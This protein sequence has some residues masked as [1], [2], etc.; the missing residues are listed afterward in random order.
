MNRTTTENA[1]LI[2]TLLGVMVA[3]LAQGAILRFR[4]CG[5]YTNV[6]ALTGTIGWYD[7]SVP[8]ATSLPGPADLIRVNNGCTVT[9]TTVEIVGGFQVGVDESGHLV[10]ASGGELSAVGSLANAVGYNG[11]AQN[12]YGRMTVNTNGEVNCSYYLHVGYTGFGVVTIDGGTL[13]LSH[14]LWVGGGANGN[15]TIILTNG[16]T[17]NMTGANNNNGMIGLGTINAVSPSGGIGTIKVSDGSVLNLFT[18]DGQG[19]SIQPG[20]VLDISGSGVVTVPGDK[21]SVLTDYYTSTGKIT[22]YGGT[23]TV[24][25]DYDVSNPGKTTLKATGG[26]VPP[27]DCTWIATSGSGLWSDPA[28]WSCGVHPVGVTAAIFNFPG[29]IPCTVN[30][31]A[32]ASYVIMGTNG[33]GGTL[34]ITN[35]GTLTCGS[36]DATVIGWNSNALMVVENGGSAGFALH[37]WVG[38]NPGADGTLII[39]AGTVWVGGMI[40]LGWNGGKGSIIITNGGRLI[41]RQWHPTAS[42][43]GESVLEITGTGTVV[44]TGN[45]VNSVSNYVS[46]GKITANGSPNVAYGFDPGANE[47]TLQVAPP[48]RTITGATASGGNLTF[49]Y[50]TTAGHLY[51]LESTP[52]LSPASWTRLTDSTTNATGASV[53]FTFPMS[54]DQRF[55]RTVS[56]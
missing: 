15:G 21:T 49:T 45:Y 16:G 35:G 13:N 22:A 27:T 20:S 34:I 56:P 43:Q 2:V 41:L 38:F 30:D 37:L 8:G 24:A 5:D 1:I 33:P 31:S 6:F 42:I 19:R 51:H 12:V 14:H 47:T 52:S 53:T 48:Q 11:Y 17:L 55:Y 4:G 32:M 36:G 23:G 40:G 9:V 7:P 18:I 26:Y 50:Q 28:N 54:G 3:G 25:V 39:D 46:N 10:V 44:I 29:A